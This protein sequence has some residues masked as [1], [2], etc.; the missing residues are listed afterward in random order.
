MTA[1]LVD[2]EVRLVDDLGASVPVVSGSSVS[3]SQGAVIFAGVD[4]Q[5]RVSFPRINDGSLRVS[6]NEP[7]LSEVSFFTEN[8]TSSC[9]FLLVDLNN[10]SGSYRHNSS[11]LS[12]IRVSSLKGQAERTHILDKWRIKLGVVVSTTTSSSQ[13]VWLSPGSQAFL[14]AN[15]LTTTA[16]EIDRNVLD[17]TVQSGSLQRIA[18]NYVES[19]NDLS[20]QTSLLD[21]GGRSVSVEPGDLV[22]RVQRLTNHGGSLSLHYHLWYQTKD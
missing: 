15:S 4:D 19:L 3:S 7:T 1:Y 9:Y 14:D 12:S 13:I 18:N 6:T 11:T 10:V 22:L 8:V 20:S 21:V 16:L 5:N 17:L 2:G